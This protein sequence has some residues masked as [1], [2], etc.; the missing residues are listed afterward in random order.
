MHTD[1]I[2]YVPISIVKTAISKSRDFSMLGKLWILYHGEML[3]VESSRRLG[4]G[5]VQLFPA[6][7]RN[8]RNWMEVNEESDFS[9]CFTTLGYFGDQISS[10]VPTTYSFTHA[11]GE[12]R[13]ISQHSLIL[14]GFTD[15]WMILSFTLLART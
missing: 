4:Y 14:S 7:W 11:H 1:A 12:D 2:Q 6:L 9:V 8:C 5:G 10:R 13:E 15:V 3:G